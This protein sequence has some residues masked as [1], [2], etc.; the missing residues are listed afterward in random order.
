M[1]DSTCTTEPARLTEETM[2][3]YTVAPEQFWE[4][5]R[6]AGD[7]YDRATLA[8][9]LGWTA[10]YGWGRDGW[11]LLDPPHYIAYTRDTRDGYELATNCEGDVTMYRFPT[12]KLR[13]EAI[14]ALALWFWRQHPDRCPVIQGCADGPV[15]DELRGPYRHRTS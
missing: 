2:S 14:D 4:A 11:D 15:P 8:A 3:R 7:G 9:K 10:L 6:F 1:T 5:V 12:E 13:T